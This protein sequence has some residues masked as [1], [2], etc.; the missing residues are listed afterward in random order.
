MLL[1]DNTQMLPLKSPILRNF[2]ESETLHYV[3]NSVV[4]KLIFGSMTSFASHRFPSRRY[5]KPDCINR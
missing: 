1:T 2:E 4:E 5:I 3:Y